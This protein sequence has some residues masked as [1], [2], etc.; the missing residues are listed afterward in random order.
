L[1]CTPFL[2]SL[3]EIF[4][5]Q[6]GRPFTKPKKGPMCKIKIGIEIQEGI[7]GVTGIPPQLVKKLLSNIK[8]TT[9]CVHNNMQSVLVSASIELWWSIPILHP[10]LSVV[11][12]LMICWCAIDNLDVA[13]YCCHKVFPKS[14]YD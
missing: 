5:V 3:G 6:K 14:T 13:K 11:S 7:L 12:P 4:R 1:E 10:T 8:C 9:G 2:V